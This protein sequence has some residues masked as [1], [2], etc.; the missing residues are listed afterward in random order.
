[1]AKIRC[2]SEKILLFG[3]PRYM[4]SKKKNIYKEKQSYDYFRNTSIMFKI[5]MEKKVVNLYIHTG[6]RGSLLRRLIYNRCRFFVNCMKY[7]NVKEINKLTDVDIRFI[8]LK[9]Y[10]GMLYRKRATKSYSYIAR[11]TALCF[12]RKIIVCRLCALI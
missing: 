4:H 10:R 7:A 6:K 11:F 8:V 9:T 2:L 3:N 1:M 5:I 12:I